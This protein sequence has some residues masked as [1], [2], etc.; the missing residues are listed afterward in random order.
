MATPRVDKGDDIREHPQQAVD[1]HMPTC[2]AHHNVSRPIVTLSNAVSTAG[3]RSA[4]P[5]A[6]LEQ[7]AACM[8]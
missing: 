2:Q 7:R 5:P 4:V 1:R 6:L 8:R 3:S